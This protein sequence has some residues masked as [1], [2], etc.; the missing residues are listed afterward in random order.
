MTRIEVLF[1]IA[2]ILEVEVTGLLA[3]QKMKSK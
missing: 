3:E 1:E 2:K